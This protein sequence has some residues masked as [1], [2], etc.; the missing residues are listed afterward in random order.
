MTGENWEV[1]WSSKETRVASLVCAGD[2]MIV[3][4]GTEVISYDSQG[5]IRW[6]RSMPF[7]VYRLGVDE[8]NVGLL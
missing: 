7:T 8:S 3:A 1:A 2:G 5:N 6:R 4:S